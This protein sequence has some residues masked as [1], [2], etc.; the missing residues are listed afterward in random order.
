MAMAESKDDKTCMHDAFISIG[1]TA[2]IA[3]I[4]EAIVADGIVVVVVGL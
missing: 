1:N 3:I 4:V 2:A